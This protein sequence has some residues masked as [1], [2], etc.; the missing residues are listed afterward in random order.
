MPT[1]V[2]APTTRCES[3][4]PSCGAGWSPRAAT[5]GFTQR[6]RVEYALAGGR[7]NTDA[8]DNSAGVDCSDHEVNIKILLQRAIAAGLLDAEKRDPLLMHMIDAVADLVLADNEAQANALEI[9]AV[10]A[11]A[12]VGVHARQMERLEQSAG[13]DRALEGL[14][15]AK[16]L[17]ERA[18]AGV[19][20]TSPELAVLLAYSKLELQRGAGR[21]RRA[22][23]SLP[24]RCAASTYF[25]PDLRT[26]YEPAIAS[27][28]LRR[29]IVATVTANAVVNRAGISFLSRLHDETGAALPTLARAHVVAVDVFDAGT[30]WAE[31]DALDLAVP[32]AVQDEMFLAVRRLVER[33][34]RWL[35]HHGGE[36]A[37][38]PTVDRFRPGVQAV[39]AALPELVRGGAAGRA[40]GASGGAARPGAAGRRRATPRW[41]RFPRSSCGARRGVDP[42]AVARLQFAVDE[43]LAL[44]RSGT[45]SARCRAATGGRPRPGPRSA[46]TSTSRVHALTDAVLRET[47]ATSPP[48]ARVDAW[49]AAHLPDGRALPAR[50]AADVERAGVFDLA[51]PRRPPAR[52][53]RARRPRLTAAPHH[54]RP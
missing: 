25:P 10:E 50:C 54:P 16:T 47:D 28:P 7:I 5:S 40:V 22:R 45:A 1:S 51:T 18:A 37:L 15:P 53:P 3:T 31:I 33:A 48:G 2:I 14:P 36:L 17:Q 6:A 20:L 42:V 52:P 11:A 41:W 8:I 44:R 12:M 43:R 26:G 39:V 30:T 38:G 35:V 49:I 4:P 27:H 21:V 24:P 32:A 34:S 19:G 13:L 23:R 9:A 46:T 29:E